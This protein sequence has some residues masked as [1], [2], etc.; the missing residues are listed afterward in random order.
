MPTPRLASAAAAFYVTQSP[1]SD[2]GD[3]AALYAD[4]PADPREL[5]RTARDLVL[6]SLEGD[7]FAYA[8]PEVTTGAVPFGAARRLFTE[9]DGLRTPRTVTTLAP[10]NGPS[11]TVLRG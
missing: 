3:L 6:H 8:A 4:L 5:A 7:L 11:R 1:F 9:N 2:P 10:F